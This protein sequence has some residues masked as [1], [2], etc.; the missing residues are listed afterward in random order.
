MIETFDDIKDVK[1]VKAQ[2]ST[3]KENV[4]ALQSTVAEFLKKTDHVYVYAKNQ[5]SNLMSMSTRM[6]RKS[7]E[8]EKELRKSSYL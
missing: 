5:Q 7:S 6:L 3:N 2:L 4:E 1:E 8:V